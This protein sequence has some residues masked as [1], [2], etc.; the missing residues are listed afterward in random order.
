MISI[1]KFVNGWRLRIGHKEPHSAIVYIRYFNG[2]EMT[3]RFIRGNI[4]GLYFDRS[5]G[6]RKL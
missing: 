1:K 4:G 3:E 5:I 2:V 6:R